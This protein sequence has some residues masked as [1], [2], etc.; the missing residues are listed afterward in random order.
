MD[1]CPNH[2]AQ[3]PLRKQDITIRSLDTCFPTMP[4]FVLVRRRE[5]AAGH[6]RGRRLHGHRRIGGALSCRGFE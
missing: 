4:D 6:R 3:R 5:A 2:L 1:S